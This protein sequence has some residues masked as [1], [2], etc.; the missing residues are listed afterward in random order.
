MK[1][2]VVAALAVALSV[3]PATFAS[4][5]VAN[6]GNGP[7]SPGVSNPGSMPGTMPPSPGTPALPVPVPG[8]Q[9][10]APSPIPV[11]TPVPVGPAS[12]GPAATP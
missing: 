3:A 6:P 12:P 1:T 8:P 11:M 10:T 7:N 4:A 9:V 5:Q 2:L